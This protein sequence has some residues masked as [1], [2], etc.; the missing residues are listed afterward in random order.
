[1]PR[2]L[3]RKVAAGMALAALSVAG[4]GCGGPTPGEPPATAPPSAEPSAQP[5]AV[6]PST[7]ATS[8]PDP[9]A[10]AI[11]AGK[12][13]IIVHVVPADRDLSST[14]EGPIAI[15]DGTDDG[16]LF[17]FL[18][19]KKGRHLLEALRAREEGGRW[20]VAV[21]TENDLA[22]LTTVECQEAAETIF[23]IEATG[24]DDDKKRPTYR[25]VNHKY[26]TLRWKPAGKVL[27]LD[28]AG[29]TPATFSFVD[30]GP[31]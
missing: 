24:A 8:K 28:Q 2:I 31:R 6:P 17:R 22:T 4:Q 30:R 1:V 11:L 13:R 20:C 29:G 14:Y 27:Y 15:G 25:I 16:A 19:A 12:R 9:K 18:P 3:S 7:P 26:G 10:A 21:Q 5:S 23:T